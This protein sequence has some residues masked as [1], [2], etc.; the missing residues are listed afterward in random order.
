M[1]G[2]AIVPLC[3]TASTGSGANGRTVDLKGVGAHLDHG[4]ELMRR[5]LLLDEDM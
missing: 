5:E 4:R 1:D 3:A 2:A